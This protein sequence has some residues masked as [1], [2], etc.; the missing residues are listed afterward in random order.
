MPHIS[1]TNYGNVPVLK[2][3]FLKIEFQFKTR[4]LENQVIAN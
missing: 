4:F 3:D 1:E 2:L